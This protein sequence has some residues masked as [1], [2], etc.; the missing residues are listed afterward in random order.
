MD[1]RETRTEQKTHDKD[2]HRER[3]SAVSQKKTESVATQ[4]EREK[5]N[6]TMYY[7]LVPSVDRKERS[8]TRFRH[9]PHKRVNPLREERQHREANPKGRR[10]PRN[11]H[12]VRKRGEDTNEARE[13]LRVSRVP[14][15]RAQGWKPAGRSPIREVRSAKEN[16]GKLTS[17]PE[18][19]P[20]R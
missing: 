18:L 15:A 20:N 5:E 17:T 9:E 1:M 13:H 4:T 2:D 14:S 6:R 8:T 19:P 3:K 10:G 16:L 12:L 7:T 11:L